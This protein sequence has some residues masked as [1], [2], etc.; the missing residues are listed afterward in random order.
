MLLEHRSGAGIFLV[1]RT[2]PNFQECFYKA[3]NALTEKMVLENTVTKRKENHLIF[4]S[5]RYVNSLCS[6]IMYSIT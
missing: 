6:I 1:F 5:S 3:N 2:L 4:S